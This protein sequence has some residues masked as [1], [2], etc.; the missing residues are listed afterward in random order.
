MKN[1]QTARRSTPKPFK[2]LAVK[3]GITPNQATVAIN[4]SGDV[5][6]GSISKIFVNGDMRSSGP[7]QP[8]TKGFSRDLKAHALGKD[9]ELDFAN[10]ETI[11]I[12]GR[13]KKVKVTFILQTT[14]N[15]ITISE[16][17]ETTLKR[18]IS[19]LPELS[20]SF[21]NRNEEEDAE[22]A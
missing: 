13:E 6:A 19:K 7:Y 11:W 15:E 20:N 12:S 14:V 1:L 9:S 8:G 17:W 2:G 3:M 16:S 21:W 18:D 10:T 5:P 22:A 4:V